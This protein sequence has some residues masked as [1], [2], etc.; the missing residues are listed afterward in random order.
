MFGEFFSSVAHGGR[1][2]L[3]ACSH[4]LYQ[5]GSKV[6]S[7]FLGVF[8]REVDAASSF[9]VLEVTLRGILGSE[10]IGSRT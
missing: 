1:S 7:P 8:A 3:S 2:C 9:Y 6:V 10:V 4:F 5:A